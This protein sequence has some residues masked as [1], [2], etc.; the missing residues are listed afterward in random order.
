MEGSNVFYLLSAVEDV[1]WL[2]EELVM[3]VAMPDSR[4]S[5]VKRKTRPVTSTSR[6][7]SPEMNPHPLQK[8]RSSKTALTPPPSV[9]VAGG[10]IQKDKSPEVQESKFA[11][12]ICLSNFIDHILLPCRHACCGSCASKIKR[13]FKKCSFCNSTIKRVD[14]FFVP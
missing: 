11:C 8:Q 10:D 14:K 6:E 1:P 7:S 3:R 12:K 13:Q 5:V 2:A 4:T 9:Q